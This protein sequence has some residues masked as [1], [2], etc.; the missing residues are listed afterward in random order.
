M[1]SGDEAAAEDIREGLGECCSVVNHDELTGSFVR[2]TDVGAVYSTVTRVPS[3]KWP[4]EDLK[5]NSGE[6]GWQKYYPRNGHEGEVVHVWYP[7]GLDACESWNTSV[8]ML[9]KVEERFYTDVSD[10]QVFVPIGA[11]GAHLCDLLP[12]K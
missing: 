9:V 4:G 2:F 7:S 10:A 1:A 3:I 12:P 11:R 5:A 8:V 6:D